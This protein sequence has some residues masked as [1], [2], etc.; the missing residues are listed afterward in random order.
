MA[1]RWQNFGVHL[2]VPINRIQGFSGGEGMVERCFTSMLATWLEGETAPTVE[3]LVSALQMP[4]VDQRV[5]A[6]D[7][8]ENRQGEHDK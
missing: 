6:M 8:D 5:L 3:K 7:I 4:G 1:P 2:E